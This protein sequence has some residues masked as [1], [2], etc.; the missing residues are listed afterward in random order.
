MLRVNRLAAAIDISA[1]GTSAPM[2]MVAN[3]TPA[4]QCGNTCSNRFGTTVFVS[5]LPLAPVSGVMW[6]AIAIT[7]NSAISPRTR[8]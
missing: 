1:D 3:A 2:K 7:P 8:L 6:A 5:G 4:N